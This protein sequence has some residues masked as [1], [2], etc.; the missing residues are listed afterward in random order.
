MVYRF[1]K[2]QI[3]KLIKLIRKYVKSKEKRHFDIAFEYA[4]NMVEDNNYIY[5]KLFEIIYNSIYF[6][7]KNETIYQ[8][9]KL[10]NIWVVE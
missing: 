3:D 10:L 6:N 2:K 9:L 4:R 7:A 8:I 5:Y 1:Y